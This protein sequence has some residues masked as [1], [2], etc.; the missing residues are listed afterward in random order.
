[1]HRSIKNIF[2]L[3]LFPIL[4]HAQQRDIKFEDVAST[5]LDKTELHVGKSFDVFL[6]KSYYYMD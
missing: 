5:I 6:G 1:M 4:L 2:S 3:I